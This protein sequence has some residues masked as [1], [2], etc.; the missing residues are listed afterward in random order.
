MV[1]GE[2]RWP[3]LGWLV[4]FLLVGPTLT[5]IVATDVR[6]GGDPAQDAEIPT[7]TSTHTDPPV[8]P[9]RETEPPRARVG[10][11]P[12]PLQSLHLG[13]YPVSPPPGAGTPEDRAGPGIGLNL[14]PDGTIL[15]PRAATREADALQAEP[16]STHDPAPQAAYTVEGAF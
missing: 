3:T 4:A 1:A 16:M 10:P 12:T 14:A 11:D 6:G 8:S 9:A 2:P 7:D 13:T 15:R 5:V